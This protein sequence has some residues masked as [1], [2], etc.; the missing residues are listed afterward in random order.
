MKACDLL[1]T[2]KEKILKCW[3]ALSLSKLPEA[4]NLSRQAIRDHLP[5]VFGALCTVLET[6]EFKVPKELSKTH[7]RQ[8]SW[9]TDYSLAEVMAEYSLLKNV[10]LDEL[11]TA[12]L[13]D[14]KDF[15]TIDRFF[16]SAST[17]ATTEFVTVREHELN[18][19]T[20]SLVTMNQ[21]LE[22]FA[23][24][25]AHD[26]RSPASTILGF[27]D[28]ISE[29]G[30]VADH[31]A[32][33][34]VDTIKRTAMRMLELIDQLLDYSKIGKEHLKREPFSPQVVAEEAKVN[35]TA[36]IEDAHA[37][38]EIEK[39]PE[40]HGD[41]I[42]FRQ[43]FQNLFSNSL[44]FRA[45]ERPLRITLGGALEQNKLRLH[46]VDN[47]VGFDPK[48]SELIFQPFKRGDARSETQGSGLG[49]ATAKKIVEL[50]G[51]KI[52]AVGHPGRG[53]ELLIELPVSH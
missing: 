48:L 30:R 35:L 37:V 4:Q 11:A 45:T 23:V 15:R 21:E 34:A 26:L 27:A 19:V 14:V 24:V 31:V 1:L 16:D 41:A 38:I 3:E 18:S 33:K 22:T 52:S 49:L 25:A 2:N 40:Y 20:D 46:I 9:T 6:G 12:K 47:G 17:I 8:R 32:I 29:E 7:G 28:L 44:K 51:G 13:F 43:L 10:I 53:A 50:H 5:Q 39:M 36:Q 42:L